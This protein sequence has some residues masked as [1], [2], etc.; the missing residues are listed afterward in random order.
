MRPCSAYTFTPVLSSQ[1]SKKWPK[2]TYESRRSWIFHAVYRLI[3]TILNSGLTQS[4]R[5]EF[6]Y[7]LW[8]LVPFRVF[9]LGD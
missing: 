3:P 6:I 4:C 5:G 7:A 8:V 9:A 1:W 2:P